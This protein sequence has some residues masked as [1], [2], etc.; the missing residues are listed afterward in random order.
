VNH[1]RNYKIEFGEPQP[2]YRFKP[3]ECIVNKNFAEEYR[4]GK[5]TLEQYDEL[6]L[7]VME[8]AIDPKTGKESYHLLYNSP[9][10]D[11]ETV[12]WGR[13]D[14]WFLK[15]FVDPNFESMRTPGTLS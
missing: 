13:L 4:Q 6:K 10:K 14:P 3:G 15:L 2:G 11:G 7:V 1:F 9:L 5:C 8:N 12:P